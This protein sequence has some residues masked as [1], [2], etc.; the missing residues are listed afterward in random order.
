LVSD[1]LINR[2]AGQISIGG[3]KT[4]KLTVSQKLAPALTA[5]QVHPLKQILF[6]LKWGRFV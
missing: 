4:G 3:G 5:A 1:N 6:L 2:A